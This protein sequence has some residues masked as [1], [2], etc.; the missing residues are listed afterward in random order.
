[1]TG[2]R[3]R[4]CEGETN[5]FSDDDAFHDR[6]GAVERAAEE[7]LAFPAV[8]VDPLARSFGR[9][10]ADASLVPMP[11]RRGDELVVTG[12]DDRAHAT[13]EHRCAASTGERLYVERRLHRLLDDQTGGRQHGCRLPGLDLKQTLLGVVVESSSTPGGEDRQGDAEGADEGDRSDRIPRATVPG[14]RGIGIAAPGA[15]EPV[16]RRSRGHG[17][18]RYD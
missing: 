1:M 2:L 12:A 15:D 5:L 18:H 17:A 10:A 7:G 4:E 8:A 11:Q 3:V 9:H 14:S 13:L 16:L 6:R